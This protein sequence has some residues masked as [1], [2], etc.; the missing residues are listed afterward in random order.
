MIEIVGVSGAFY[1][2][3]ANDI[4]R[5][6]IIIFLKINLIFK[7][8]EKKRISIEAIPIFGL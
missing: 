6:Y 7:K 1:Q 4:G 3:N 5:M 8:N 2:P